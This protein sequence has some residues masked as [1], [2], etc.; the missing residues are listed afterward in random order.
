[1]KVEIVRIE[2]GDYKVIVD[3]ILEAEFITIWGAKNFVRKMKK[4]IENS[5]KAKTIWT[6]ELK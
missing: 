4:L 1:M 5:R 2:W 3:G 6:E